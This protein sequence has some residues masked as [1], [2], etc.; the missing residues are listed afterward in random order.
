M[1]RE[2][3]TTSTVSKL[4]LRSGNW[5]KGRNMDHPT[6]SSYHCWN[7]FSAWW[8]RIIHL[9]IRPLASSHLCRIGQRYFPSCI[10]LRQLVL[11]GRTTRS[12]WKFRSL[13]LRCEFLLFLHRTQCSL[14]FF[15]GRPL[16]PTWPGFPNFDI[17]TFNEDRPGL[18]LWPLLN[19]SCMCEQYVK[20][21]RVTDSMWLVVAFQLF[22]SAD[23]QWFEVC[24]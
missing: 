9:R 24:P 19:I 1:E 13:L 17:K 5:L 2:R 11:L 18:I 15:I 4:P 12:R 10:R 20:Y 8:N 21:G 16:N 6:R 7:L 3:C 14:Q 23:C 22:Y